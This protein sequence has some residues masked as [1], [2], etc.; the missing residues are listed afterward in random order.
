MKQKLTSRKLWLAVAGLVVG[1][2]ALFGVNANMT[3]QISGVIMSLG[4]VVAYIVGEGLVD[5]ASA[6]ASINVNGNPTIT[7][8][9]I[10]TTPLSAPVVGTVE[11]V[12]CS[13]TV[14]GAAQA[15]AGKADTAESSSTVTQTAAAI[16]AAVG[17]GSKQI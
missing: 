4:S 10:A 9:D 14:T 11:A 15:A 17:G 5:A 13:N 6:G 1:V 16:T 8:G 3:Q 2:L 12:P 7:A